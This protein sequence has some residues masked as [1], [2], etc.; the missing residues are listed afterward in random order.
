[1]DVIAHRS[2][3]HDWDD[4]GEPQITWDD[5]TA[6]DNMF[7][8]ESTTRTP[9]LRRYATRTAVIGPDLLDNDDEPSEFEVLGDSA[10]CTG[11]ARAALADA[12]HTAIIKPVPLRP[13]AAAGFT[14]DDFTV[15]EAAGTVICPAGLTR[16]LT[17]GR[18]AVFGA[19]CGSCPLRAR[20]TEAKDG[21]T[22]RLQNT[23][24]CYARP[25]APGP[26]T[27]RARSTGSTDP[28]SNARSPA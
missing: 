20:C 10:Y 13:A 8:R 2:H 19:A 24:P 22:V 11:D 27:T 28:W 6:R 12:G 1:V 7:R 4:P 3:G 23:T 17:P 9:S 14:L 5:K 26:L 25:A 18:V 15:D 21:R 16:T